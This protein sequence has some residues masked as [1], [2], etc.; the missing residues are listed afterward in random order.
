[1][2]TNIFLSFF[3]FRLAY[4]TVFLDMEMRGKIS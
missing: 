1:M 4:N 2:D 3:P